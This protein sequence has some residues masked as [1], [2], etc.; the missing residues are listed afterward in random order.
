MATLDILV[1]LHLTGALMIAAGTGLGEVVIA[2]IRRA[3][4]TTAILALLN[5][6]SRA[7]VMTFPGSILA[8]VFGSWLVGATGRSFGEMWLSIAF[9][10]WGIAAA[11]SVTIVSPAF[12]R[13]HALAEAELSAGREESHALLTAVGDPKLAIA[14]HLLSAMLLISLIVMVFKPGA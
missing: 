3:R 14:T 6:G 1:F 10:A 12:R 5:A 9:L 4:S 11:T 2:G 7:P 8:I 13:L